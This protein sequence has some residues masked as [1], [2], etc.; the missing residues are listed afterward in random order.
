MSGVSKSGPITGCLPEG[1]SLPWSSF[2]SSQ[3]GNW[4]IQIR[5]QFVVILS[6][7]PRGASTQPSALSER[8]EPSAN[9]NLQSTLLLA[10]GS[11][12]LPAISHRQMYSCQTRWYFFHPRL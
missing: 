12:L 1:R 2:D 11:H 10:N 6:H 7:M 4:W 3:S 5:P 9:R 8:G